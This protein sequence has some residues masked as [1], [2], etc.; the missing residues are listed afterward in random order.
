MRRTLLVGSS[1]VFGFAVACGAAQPDVVAPPPPPPPPVAP[2]IPPH[3]AVPPPPPGVDVASLD[4]TVS[5]CD[6]FFQYACGGWNK[7]NPIPDD[8]ARWGRFNALAEQNELALREILEKDAASASMKGPAPAKKADVGYSKALGN[9]YASCMDEA[10]VEKD[11][12]TALRPL[13]RQIDGIGDAKALAKTVADLHLAGVNALFNV[14]SEQ[15]AKDATQMIAG[16][17]QG[18]LGMPDRDYYLKDDDEKILKVRAAYLA[19]VERIFELL[20]DKP[21]LAKT[22]AASVLALEKELAFAQITRV[23][24][25]DPQKVYHKMDRA[26]V[27]QAAPGFAWDAYWRELGIPKVTAI[28]LAVPTFFSGVFTAPAAGAKGASSVARYKPYLRLHLARSLAKALPQAFIDES[29]AFDKELTGAA[30]ILPR[31]KR[32][33]RAVDGAMGEALAIPFVAAK[34]GQDGKEVTQSMVKQIEGA[35]KTDLDGLSWMDAPTRAKALEKVHTL[36][37]KIGYPDTW[38]SYDTLASKIRRG[39]YASNLVAGD[40]FELARKLAQVGK[41]V[42]RAEWDMT[43]PTVN[44]YYNPQL[45]EMVFPAGILQSPFFTKGAPAPINFGGLGMVMG[46]ELTHGF[47]DEGRQFD[48]Q[49][50]LKEWW[51]PAVSADFDKKAACVVD[52]FDGYTAIDNLHVN[53]KLTLGENL[54]DLGGAKLALAVVHGTVPPSDEVD[55]QFFFGISQIWCGSMRPEQQSVRVR[56]DPHSPAKWRVNGP[57][58]NMPEFAHAFACR[59]GD[60]MVRPDDKRCSVW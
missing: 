15:D 41:P 20:G 16:L 33:V 50:N 27:A 40:R 49:G 18:G 24:H 30:K 43:P 57:L 23:D 31:W 55:R 56:T 47:D 37:N 38:R 35:M 21:A 8:Q 2:V 39:S 48:P 58:S 36:F 32:C 60:A 52:Q 45:N 26:G 14:G 1:L 7:A 51:S 53:G 28:N 54:A 34:L 10:G 3:A 4:P 9:F 22:E 19:H 17:D 59:A 46:H 6:D 25:R 42:D 44:A 29:F 11:G 5:P 12:I 13:L